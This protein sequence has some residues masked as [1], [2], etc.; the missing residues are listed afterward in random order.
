MKV[1][2]NHFLTMTHNIHFNKFSV[3]IWTKNSLPEIQS[4][5][6]I[7][8]IN[9]NKI[10]KIIANSNSFRNLFLSSNKC[11]LVHCAAR[12]YISRYS[13]FE[14]FVQSTKLIEKIAIYNRI[15]A[16]VVLSTLYHYSRCRQCQKYMWHMSIYNK[17][18]LWPCRKIM[19]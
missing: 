10:M 13:L 3:H 7:K 11:Y 15:E 2:E 14:F 18:K 12:F 17:I 4:E 6:K 5:A 19:K 16:R 8:K 1:K 9:W